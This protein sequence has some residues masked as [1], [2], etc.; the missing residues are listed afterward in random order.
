MLSEVKAR[1]VVG[2]TATPQRRDGHQAITHMQ[3]G[4]VRFE[5]SL[6]DQAAQRPFTHRLVVRETGFKT[7]DDCGASPIQ[8][9]Y[10]ALASDEVRNQQILRDVRCALQE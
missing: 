6:K 2:L 4:P 9:L 3:L 7:R 8:R 1:Y 10:A 5:L